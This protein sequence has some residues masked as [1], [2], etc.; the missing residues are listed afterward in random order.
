[1]VL[2]P[3]GCTPHGVERMVTRMNG[4]VEIH[5][6]VI[7]RTGTGSHWY[8]PYVYLDGHQCS[9]VWQMYPGRPGDGT[10]VMSRDSI[11]TWLAYKS[12]NPV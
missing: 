9:T 1:M 3:S 4:V 11:E 6:H 12:G 10:R 8:C 7:A 5:T 2:R